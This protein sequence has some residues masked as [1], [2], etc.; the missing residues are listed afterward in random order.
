M[1]KTNI[2]KRVLTGMVSACIIAGTLGTGAAAAAPQIT[3]V[4]AT[5]NAAIAAAAS[6]V[7]I[8]SKTVTTIKTTA[9][10]NLRKGA[11][12]KHKSI[13]TLKKGTTVTKTGKTNGKWWQVKANGKT[14]WVSSSYLKTTKTTV[15]VNPP[16]PAPAPAPK[17]ASKTEYRWAKDV[18]NVR[19]G[20]GTSHRS[21]GTAKAW[22]KMEYLGKTNNGW[23]YVK[24]SRGKGWISNNYLSKTEN[25]PVAV[26][27]TLRKGQ[28]A[29]G[30]LKGRTVK[31]VK[32]TLPGHTLY[33]KPDVTWWSFLVPDTKS[34]KNV[35]AERMTIKPASYNATLRELDRWERFDPSKPLADQNY[36]RKLVTDKDGKK[37]YAYVAGEKIAKYMKKQGIKVSTGDYLKRY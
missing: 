29:Y 7:S 36:N 1:S 25:Y 28:S 19:T 22:E 30:L 15:K 34:S 6:T 4:G 26:Y 3:T 35:V 5:A 23:S 33:L 18:V 27:G 11:G 13:A 24:S 20:A 31:E 12:T 21:L 14:G 10:L 32:T 8:A 2:N 17:P 16:K 37:S 9:N